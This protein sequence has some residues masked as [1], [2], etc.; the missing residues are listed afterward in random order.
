MI[1]NDARLYSDCLM[2]K[3]ED[4]ASCRGSRLL[5]K[6]LFWR[7]TLAAASLPNSWSY[8]WEQIASDTDILATEIYSPYTQSTHAV[9]VL[10]GARKLYRTT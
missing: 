8:D 5:A 2:D 3:T 7:A 10:Q 9:P 1:G 6:C 4:A